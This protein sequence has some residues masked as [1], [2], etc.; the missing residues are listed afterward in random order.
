MVDKLIGVLGTVFAVTALGIALRPKA[1]TA[2][3]ITAAGNAVASMQ[4]ASF[5][6]A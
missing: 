3:V 6:P 5:G 4:K 1:N 2:K